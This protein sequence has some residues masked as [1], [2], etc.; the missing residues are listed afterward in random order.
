MTNEV[1][2][3]SVLV[4]GGGT[5]IGA[6]IAR[7]LAAEGAW[8]TVCGRTQASLRSTVDSINDEAGREAVRYEIADV[9]SE[10][11]VQR[12]IE[13]AAGWRQRLDGVVANA[14]GGGALAPLHAQKVDEFTRVLTLN[15]VGTLLLVKHSVPLFARAGVGSFVAISSIA[16]HVTHPYFGAYPVAKAAVEELIRN[17]ADEYGA[18]GIRFNAVRPGLTSTE[19][20][21]WATPGSPVYES[22]DENTPLGGASDVDDVAQLVSFLL[23]SR[24]GRVTGQI[25]NVDGGL[26]L[27]RG[28]D[29]SALVA[30]RFGGR[31]ALLGK[32]EPARAGP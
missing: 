21:S 13:A 4:T 5:G 11:D 19:I 28:P 22:Y 3:L 27:R 24:A 25:V 9:T 29:Y 2:G 1:D 32:A 17:A 16:G 15:V 20:M 23:S 30:P 14:G 31:D 6:G 7:R 12:V 10:P 18:A 8:V 26:S